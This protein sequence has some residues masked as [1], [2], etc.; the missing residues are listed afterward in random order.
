MLQVMQ[1]FPAILQKLIP[2]NLTLTMGGVMIKKK[3]KIRLNLF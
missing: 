1:S 2:K 3:R